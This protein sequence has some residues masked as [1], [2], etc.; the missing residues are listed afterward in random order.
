MSERFYTK[1]HEWIN[2]A[3]G[4]AGISQYA[5][6]HLGDI[7]YVEVTALNRDVKKGDTVGVV[8]SVKATSDIYSPADGKVLEVNP[9]LANAPDLLNKDPYGAGWMF[10]LKLAGAPAKADLMDEAAYQGYLK[11][12]TE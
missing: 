8:E 5:Q 3:T 11:T 9:A 2:P 1:S 6:E 4:Q 7:V 12:V 10:K